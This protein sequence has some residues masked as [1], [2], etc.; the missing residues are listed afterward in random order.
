[1]TDVDTVTGIETEWQICRQGVQGLY[2]WLLVGKHFYQYVD[3][4]VTLI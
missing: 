4:M 3:G 2:T 1:M